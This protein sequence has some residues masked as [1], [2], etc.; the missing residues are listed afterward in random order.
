MGYNFI[1]AGDFFSLEYVNLTL[2]FYTSFIAELEKRDIG[3]DSKVPLEE[4]CKKC[5]EEGIKVGKFI[6]GQSMDL[7]SSLIKLEEVWRKIERH[8]HLTIRAHQS[9][10]GAQRLAIQYAAHCWLHAI[11]AAGHL[12]NLLIPGE[13]RIIQNDELI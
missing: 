11:P 6:R 12:D 1:Y 4:L 7:S 10:I 5:M 3:A 2:N 13:Y 9:D 8:T